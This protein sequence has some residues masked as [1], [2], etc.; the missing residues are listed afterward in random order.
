MWLP[1]WRRHDFSTLTE[2]VKTRSASKMIID[3]PD[4]GLDHNRGEVRDNQ[5]IV[6]GE[7]IGPIVVRLVDHNNEPCTAQVL[8]EISV[9][10]TILS[11]KDEDTDQW[12]ERKSFVNPKV[13]ALPSSHSSGAL[14][15]T[16]SLISLSLPPSLF[17][18]C[19]V[20]LQRT[21][22]RLVLVCASQ[23]ERQPRARVLQAAPGG[24]HFIAQGQA[25]QGQE[26][27]GGRAV[28][29]ASARARGRD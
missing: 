6:V 1:L 28:H 14:C 27:Q 12:T 5:S 22:G 10:M 3:F 8:K 18:G 11:L 19:Q 7:P 9:T 24:D 26:R 25:G 21:G 13:R 4:K 17:L 16:P 20:R 29:R 23:H 2:V 15:V